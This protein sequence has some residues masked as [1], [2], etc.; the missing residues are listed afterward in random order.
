MPNNAVVFEGG[1]EIAVSV[2]KFVATF[3][4]DFL[5]AAA[6]SWT[7]RYAGRARKLSARPTAG[8]GASRR[9]SGYLRCPIAG[10]FLN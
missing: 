3:G 2:M 8:S 5:D 6:M 4:G 9:I 7:A 1:S 10:G